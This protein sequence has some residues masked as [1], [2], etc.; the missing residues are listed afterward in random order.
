MRIFV[1]ILLFTPFLCFSQKKVVDSASIN[2]MVRKVDKLS[3]ANNRSFTKDK[4]INHKKIKENWQIFDNKKM[5]RIII[6]YTINSAKYSVT[7][8]EKYYFK[9]SLLIYA[10]ESEIFFS[11]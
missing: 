7:Y 8:S 9:D 2:E 5:M 4:I 1:L 3:Y 10:Y 11:P 6:S